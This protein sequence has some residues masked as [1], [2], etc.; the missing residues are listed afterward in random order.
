MTRVDDEAGTP[1]LAEIAGVY[2]A[3][4]PHFHRGSH[5]SA[6][7]RPTRSSLAVSICGRCHWAVDRRRC[8]RRLPELLDRYARTFGVF[9]EGAG[10]HE[11]TFDPIFTPDTALPSSAKERLTC[12]RE[13][14]AAHNVGHFRFFECSVLD[15]AGRPRGDMALYGDVYFPYDPELRGAG[16]L[17][18]VPVER[19]GEGPRIVEQYSLD[20]SGIVDVLIRDVE[21]SFER[22]YRFGRDVSEAR[23]P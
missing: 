13:Y 4:A 17:A 11:I 16:D 2:V 15:G 19:R 12:T 20:P 7:L 10:G 8:R 5:S 1:D 23:S 9:R 14:R 3:G 21:G 6:T 22:A 18:S